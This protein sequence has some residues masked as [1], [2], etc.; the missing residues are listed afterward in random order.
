MYV[1]CIR[2]HYS[3][4]TAHTTDVESSRVCVHLCQRESPSPRTSTTESTMPRAPPARAVE[5]IGTHS[6]G[7]APS[8]LNAGENPPAPNCPGTPQHQR[9]ATIAR[10]RLSPTGSREPRA[11]ASICIGDDPLSP[12]RL[13]AATARPVDCI[14]AAGLPHFAGVGHSSARVGP[15]MCIA[16]IRI[17][18]VADT[19]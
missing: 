11:V 1:C 17:L 15:A 13:V 4:W 16:C 7:P 8:A 2:D 6:P 19:C 14:V 9:R 3:P 10:P 5:T 12:L 18:V